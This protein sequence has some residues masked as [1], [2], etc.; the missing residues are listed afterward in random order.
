MLKKISLYLSCLCLGFIASA[1]TSVW[2]VSSG[3]SE[4]YL[5]GTFHL[6]R[7]TDFPLPEEFYE[8][9][10]DSMHL[11]F[12][13]DIGMMEG[14]GA[15][16]M[17]MSKGMLQGKT[18]TDV[19]SPETY[20]ALSN[21]CSNI[22]IPIDALA[23]FKPSI[24]V[25]TIAVGEMQKIGLTQ[26]G[27]DMHFYKRGKEDGKE[28]FFLEKVEEQIDFICAMGEGNEDEFV[29]KSLDELDQAK[30]ELEHMIGLWKNGDRAGL[31]EYTNAA[32]KEEYP[33][34]YK[35]LLVDRNK[36][37]MPLIQTLLD[38]EE[39]EFVLVGASH[40]VGEEG[41]LTQLEKFGC[42]VKQL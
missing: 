35:S 19:L 41:L 1:E 14:P 31:N 33:D 15:Q 10:Q 18:L 20:Q 26:E 23:G 24:V 37:W 6:L 32:M 34:L 2:K 7:A 29:S 12:E 28:M 3:D 25:V 38:S 40:L 39:K 8:A 21:A 9:Y 16:Q 5:G 17:I 36:Q 11:V 13:T 22:G 27:V 30:S 42:T 4:I